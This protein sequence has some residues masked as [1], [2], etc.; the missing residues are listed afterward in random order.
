MLYAIRTYG[1]PVLQKVAEPVEHIND[2]LRQL[3]TEMI[4]IMYEA[5][6][7]GLAAPQ[8]GISKRLFVY[9][10]GKG[11]GAFA[12]VNPTLS[13]LQGSEEQPEGCLS[14]P[15]GSAL[16]P[17][18]KEVR[19]TGWDENG[20]PIDRKAK[21]FLAQILQHECDHLDGKLFLHHLSPSARMEILRK[22]ARA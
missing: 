21:G 9:D 1:D 3:V 18:A 16:V 22:G 20:S 6:G 10:D 4:H 8:I 17:R 11:K 19:L 14:V 12:V 15:G 5:P 7:V 13:D 2:D